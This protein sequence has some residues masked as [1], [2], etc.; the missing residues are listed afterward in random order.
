MQTYIASPFFNEIQNKQVTELEDLLRKLGDDYYSPRNHGNNSVL[1]VGVNVEPL[2][3]QLMFQ[4]NM[5]QIRNRPRIIVNL[6]DNYDIG[7]LFELG[8]AIGYKKTVNVLCNSDYYNTFELDT[9]DLYKSPAVIK[10]PSK[11]GIVNMM[12]TLEKL[13]GV[14][15]SQGTPVLVDTNEPD[16]FP[17]GIMLLGYL[18]A[19]GVPS[20]YI[21]NFKSKSNLMITEAG[22]MQYATIEDYQNNNPVNYKDSEIQ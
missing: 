16:S 5:Y 7:T 1:K 11:V 15:I 10:I 19:R 18:Y 8:A 12:Q 2:K 20:C 14:F 9:Q 22:I 13:D 6:W 4:D 21:S 3:R 17:A